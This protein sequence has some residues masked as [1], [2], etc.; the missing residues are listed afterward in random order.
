MPEKKTETETPIT[1]KLFAAAGIKK[2]VF[3]DD[4]YGITHKRVQD[5][6]DE[7]SIEQLRDS[8]AFSG[9][10]FG[11]DSEEV[12]R[13]SIAKI[14]N[15]MESAALEEAFDR[16][17]A[18]R[19]GYDPERDKTANRY[20]QSIVGDAVEAVRL[21]LKEWEKHR[22]QHLAAASDNATLFIFD[23]D[24]SL[25]GQGKTHGRVL[26]DQTHTRNPGYKFVYA[27]LTHNVMSDQDEIDLEKTIVA[28]MPSI[29]GYVLVVSK[30]RLE[31]NG[32]RFANR[33]KQLLLAR[34]FLM[35]Q[36]RLRE[37]TEAASSQ[38]I[39][40]I[41]GLRI[42]SFER[43]ILGTSQFEGAWSPETLVRV[44]GVSQQQQIKEKI[45]RDA[46]LHRS[47]REI[48]PICEV[49]TSLL[50]DD[51]TKDAQRLQH[52][53]IYETS[54]RINEVNLPTSSGDIVKDDLG[55]EYVLLAQPC[56]LMVRS[57]G[58][59]R[60]PERDSRQLVPLAPIV[61]VESK[62]KD[63]GL[64]SDQYEFPYYEAKTRWCVRFNEV[65]QLPLWLLDMA[66]FNDQGACN[67]TEGQ[68][69]S[70]LLTSPWFK[71]PPILLERAANIVQAVS[72][73]KEIDI[74]KATLLQSYCRVPL[75]S[76]FE[77][78]LS[79]SA[80]EPPKFTLALKLARKRRVAEQ[81][82]TGLLIDYAA[83]T[84][85]LAHPHDLGRVK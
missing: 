16:M 34:R 1:A 21:S 44:I 64:P 19:T 68:T 84:A 80:E 11:S 8:A 40:E 54:A 59:R 74:D 67:L 61:K 24:F 78:Q 20:F 81:H 51:V 32:A 57:S 48:D 75:E 77:T 47:V 2:V 12:Q 26:I 82:S 49:K 50:S 7:L 46:E 29:A 37:E 27:L 76:P 56:D 17:A 83:Y 36:K 5:D 18:I 15:T 3:V 10:D 28:E 53:E 85:R 31:E 33:L 72:K 52:D 41:E 69:P 6:A 13:A 60:N 71:L 43:I 14:I 58:F 9:V 62:Y 35:L 23:E 39:K 45:R 22:E 73:V 70:P 38:A 79:M 30:S 63:H 42:E 65:Y 4:R 66:V 25:E 55:Q